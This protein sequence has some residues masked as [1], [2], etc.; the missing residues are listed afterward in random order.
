MTMSAVPL[1]AF[2]T[3][4]EHIQAEAV[5]RL[6]ETFNQRNMAL[7]AIERDDQQRF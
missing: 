5:R 7:V 1:F 4:L 6:D 3:D 2:L